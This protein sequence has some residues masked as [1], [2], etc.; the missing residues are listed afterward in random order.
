VKVEFDPVKDAENLDKHGVPL[1]LAESFEWEIAAVREDKREAYGE[2]RFEATSFIGDRIFVFV[3]CLRGD[4][5]V[6]AISLRKALPSEA[7]RYANHQS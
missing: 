2:Q 3:F 6:R 7:R 1:I 4:D 5:V